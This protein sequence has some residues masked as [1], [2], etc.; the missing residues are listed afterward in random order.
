MDEYRNTALKFYKIIDELRATRRV[1]IDNEAHHPTIT[2]KQQKAAELANKKLKALHEEL[3]EIVAFEKQEADRKLEEARREG[4]DPN[5]AGYVQINAGYAFDGLSDEAI[6]EKYPEY[7]KN[8]HPDDKPYRYVVDDLVKAKVRAAG[9]AVMLEELI[10]QNE[11]AKEKVA[12]VGKAR[13]DALSDSHKTLTGL[14]SGMIE[15]VSKGE[16]PAEHD[17]AETFD[18]LMGSHGK[19]QPVMYEP[20]AGTDKE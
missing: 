5:R 8:L 9:D 6:L 3:T 16:R 11:S 1:I 19:Y 18:G 15:S 7:V 12:A 13:T 10:S 2:L 4:K 20:A 17:I 14:M